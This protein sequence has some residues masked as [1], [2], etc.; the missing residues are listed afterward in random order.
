[1]LTC[2]AEYCVIFVLLLISAYLVPAGLFHYLFFTRCSPAT[3][4]MRIQ[5]RRP[6]PQSVRREIRASVLALLLFSAYSLM[7]YHAARNG[8]TT[9]YLDFGEHPWWWAAPGFAALV[10]LHDI[11][12]YATHR[13][14]HLAPLFKAVHAGHHSSITP[15]PWAILSF[16]PLETIPQF[17]FFALVIFLLPLH[18][19][20]LLAYLLFDGVVNAAGH[21]GHEIVPQSSQEHWLLKY[22]NAV[23]HHDLHHSRFRYNFGQYF[24]ICDRLFGTFLDRPPA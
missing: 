24:N 12:F 17:G 19:A 7:V 20:T 1:M 16:Q 22:L 3:E 14:M 15:T 6:R 4:A 13:L 8:A 2:V 11:Y 18:P 21:C 9:L 23:T 10:V 5:K